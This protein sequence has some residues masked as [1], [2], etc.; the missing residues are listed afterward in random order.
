MLKEAV[1]YFHFY[2]PGSAVD[3]VT[4]EKTAPRK[5]RR[6]AQHGKAD[7]EDGLPF[8]VPPG[9][10]VHR[11]PYALGYQELGPVY[12]NK[13]EEAPKIASPVRG[14]VGR[15]AP[16]FPKGYLLHHPLGFFHG[17]FFVLFDIRFQLGCPD[18]EL[19]LYRLRFI[20]VPHEH[21]DAPQGGKKIDALFKIV[22]TV[23]GKL[24]F[25]PVPV[26]GQ[27]EEFFDKP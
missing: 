7:N 17:L 12:G 18:F 9:D 15:Q 26:G 4:P 2:L 14:K 20:P 16:V 11:P 3:K 5:H 8:K 19:L 10:K 25:F 23:G 21:V 6:Y 22:N 27:H 24:V 13:T 1:P